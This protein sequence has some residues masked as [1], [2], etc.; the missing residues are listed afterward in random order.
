MTRPQAFIWLHLDGSCR[1]VFFP[2]TFSDKEFCPCSGFFWLLMWLRHPCH[3]LRSFS[4]KQSNLSE[5]NLS[6]PA[7]YAL[8]DYYDYSNLDGEEICSVTFRFQVH[9]QI[10]ILFRFEHITTFKYV[11]PQHH[12]LHRND[13]I[14]RRRHEHRVRPLATFYQHLKVVPHPFYVGCDDPI[15]CYCENVSPELLTSLF[16]EVWE[17]RVKNK[18]STGLRSCFGNGCFCGLTCFSKD[19]FI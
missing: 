8:L 16:A 9:R 2:A 3:S 15:V 7:D 18:S 1:P 19:L 6:R 10:C 17:T 13:G 11:L 4:A 12:Q 5:K 14:R